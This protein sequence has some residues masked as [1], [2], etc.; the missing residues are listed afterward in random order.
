MGA[1]TAVLAQCAEDAGHLVYRQVEENP[2]M[3]E[4]TR[5]GTPRFTHEIELWRVPD[6]RFIERTRDAGFVQVFPVPRQ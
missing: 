3:Y 1:I 4:G 2:I 6:A 5:I